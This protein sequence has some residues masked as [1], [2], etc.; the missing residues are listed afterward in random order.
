MHAAK[1]GLHSSPDWP[2][3]T[4]PSAKECK[5]NYAIELHVEIGYPQWYEETEG[6]PAV[7]LTRL[8]Q[9]RFS[10]WPL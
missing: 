5:E 4:L 6:F 8:L 2:A 10:R 9:G 1:I 3:G 7:H